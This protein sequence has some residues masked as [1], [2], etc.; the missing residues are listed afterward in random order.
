MCKGL[1]SKSEKYSKENKKVRE[2]VAIVVEEELTRI[3]WFPW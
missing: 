3:R 1:V 2:K